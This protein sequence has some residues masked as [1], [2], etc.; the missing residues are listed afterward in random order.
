MLPPSLPPGQ[1]P[2]AGAAALPASPKV[3][4]DESVDAMADGFWL[5]KPFPY[6]LRLITCVLVSATRQLV[7]PSLPNVPADNPIATPARVRRRGTSAGHK[8]GTN[9]SPAGAGVDFPL[10][11]L[12]S[13]PARPH[14]AHKR[15]RQPSRQ[16]TPARRRT[17]HDEAM[18]EESGVVF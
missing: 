1:F 5:I 16:S 13:G 8:P 2:A 7:K 18:R 14:N 12:S 3:I 15:G 6:I 10:I 4:A 17:H 11:R 9:P